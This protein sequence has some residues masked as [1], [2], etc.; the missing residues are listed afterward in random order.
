[1]SRSRQADT[2]GPRPSGQ[3]RRTRGSRP[4]G[5]LRRFLPGLVVL[6]GVLVAVVGLRAAGVF[7]PP[8]AGLDLNAPQLRASRG[9]EVGAKV[10]SQG[11]AHIPDGRRVSYSTTPPTSGP[12]WQ[13]WASWGIKEAQEPNER[14]THNLE[15]GGVV[16]AHRGLAPEELDRLTSV[17]RALM[18]GGYPKIILEPYA[19][20]TDAKIALTA[21]QWILKMPDYDEA[22]VVR[23]VRAHHQGPDAPEPNAP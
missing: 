12:H 16:I 7:E 15:H 17:V 8:L 6:G 4:P 23:F 14:T 9:D 18:R 19:E 1:M 10:P 5:L 2:R 20:L 3:R 11:G 13:R 21:W 22:Q